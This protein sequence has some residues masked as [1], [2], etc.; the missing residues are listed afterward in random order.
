M[1][2]TQAQ[3]IDDQITTDRY[4]FLFQYLKQARLLF[5]QWRENFRLE[6]LFL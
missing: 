2:I 5:E 1:S 4:D 6:Y 3:F